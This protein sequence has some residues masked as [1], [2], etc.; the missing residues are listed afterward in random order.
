[1]HVNL[2]YIEDISTVD[3]HNKSSC[4]VFFNECP[5]KCPTCHNKIT[6][7]NINLI[8]TSIIKTRIRSCLPFISA[9]VFSGGEPTKQIGPLLE[10]CQFSKSLSL[11]VAIES[12]GFYPENLNRLKPFV[13][14]F[15]IDVKAPIN[16]PSAYFNA[17]KNKHAYSRINY[18]LSLNL[19]IKIRIVDINKSLTTQII[20][21]LPK[22]FEITTLPYIIPPKP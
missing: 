1:M 4:V 10:L 18:T 8:D 20:D 9:V 2:N 22:K 15:Y 6:W 14:I 3:Y 13:D 12:N 7:N 16:S 11:S 21:S 17:T 19:P 5:F